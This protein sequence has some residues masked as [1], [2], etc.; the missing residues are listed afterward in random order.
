VVRR[1][2]D[3]NTQDPLF[4][5]WR[6]H[7]FFTNSTEPVGQADPTH[8]GHAICE[9]V[10]SDLIDGPWAGCPESLP[11]FEETATSSTEV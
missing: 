2:L 1:V 3:A 7:P 9:Q 10:W 4:P 6:H 8:R 11:G 5:A